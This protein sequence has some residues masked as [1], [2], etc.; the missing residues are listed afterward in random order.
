MQLAGY[1][2]TFLKYQSRPKVA[3][4]LEY[5]FILSTAIFALS[6]AMATM[7]TTKFEPCDIEINRITAC[8][9]LKRP[10]SSCDSCHS[11]IMW[12]TS[13]S[14]LPSYRN[15]KVHCFQAQSTS[16]WRS[17]SNDH[18]LNWMFEKIWRKL[19]SSGEG[20]AKFQEVYS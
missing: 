1:V 14:V 10:V 16:S 5:N 20:I 17:F 2:W 15:T 9:C 6:E 13:T 12:R 11:Y 4:D 8:C 3:L 7:A 19:N 18:D